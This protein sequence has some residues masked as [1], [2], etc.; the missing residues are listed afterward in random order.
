MKITINNIEC[1]ATDGDTILEVARRNEIQI[2]SIC[3]LS[4]CS[5]TLAC[6]MCMVEV[7]GKRTYSCNAKVKDG[8]QI[9]S[10]TSEILQERKEIMTTYC[11]NH[12]LECGVCDKSGECELQDFVLHTGVDIQSF[13][14]THSFMQ[15]KRFAQTYY[16][17]YLCILCER[18]VTTCK[19]NIGESNLKSAKATLSMPDAYKDTMNK[20]PYSV[21]AKRQ[22]GI[23]DFIG[24]YECQDCGECISVCPVGAMTYKDFTY[25]SNAWELEKR[26]SACTH[27]SGGCD[28]IYNVKH[29][30]VAGSIDKIYRVQNDYLY[31]PICGA[32]RFAFDKYS[33]GLSS[34]DFNLKTR[35]LEVFNKS[36]AIN[37]G[38]SATNEEI[39][40]I[41]ALATK[42][43]LK[44][45]NDEAYKFSEFRNLL[46]SFNKNDFLFAK[47]QDVKNASFIV[48]I[49]SYFKY[50][51]PS[52]RYKVNNNLKIKKGSKLI[53]FTK[54]KDKLVQ[55]LSKNVVEISTS[56]LKNPTLASLIALFFGNSLES[57][58]LNLLKISEQELEIIKNNLLTE[59]QLQDFNAVKLSKN[60]IIVIAYE[61]LN[62]SSFIISKLLVTLL[63]DLD[64]KLLYI[65]NGSNVI[66]VANLAKLS[67]RTSKENNYEIGFRDHGD[68]IFD[69]DFSFEFIDIAMD[70]LKA[71]KNSA[72]T[73]KVD[74]PIQSLNQSDGSITNIENRVLAL[75][76]ATAFVDKDFNSA[77]DISDVASMLN[78]I[79]ISYLSDLTKKL[80][81]IN[82][83]YKDVKYEDLKLNIS[84]N[85]LDD[86]GYEL[87]YS[88]LIPRDKNINEDNVNFSINEISQKI[89]FNALLLENQNHF[90]ENTML[91]RN[92][93]SKVGIYTNANLL[94]KNDLNHGDLIEFKIDSK[95]YISNI[96]LDNDLDSDLFLISPLLTKLENFYI[97]LYDLKKLD[98][99][100][101]KN[102]IAKEN[103]AEELA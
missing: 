35:L 66:G 47:S 98:N 81:E 3:Y 22:K 60:G 19:D 43:N 45:Y 52:I 63:S 44:I 91:S 20:D 103:R 80:H 12:P 36:H 5:P 73:K 92:L 11:V 46:F 8:M 57:K 56:S 84:K 29:A 25:K 87:D 72:E 23:I 88:K 10:N 65:P 9:L 67:K 95:L 97:T 99:T 79:D 21:W 78:A 2:P 69:C 70:R 38:S 33:I 27:C 62:E 48:S 26:H 86:R 77:L 74:F 96:Y 17:P 30:D 54:F 82:P 93:Q 14:V 75:N 32:G 59:F 89:E 50:K 71:L 53:N 37:L 100:E 1:Q 6:K 34:I 4:N 76:P 15:D 7:D 16:D 94:S 83:I 49:E 64:S 39:L 42:F 28:L 41:N 68:F 102:T 24:R 55:S 58:L 101:I 85:G 40:V 13:G 31:N 51:S 90:N 61:A 18:C